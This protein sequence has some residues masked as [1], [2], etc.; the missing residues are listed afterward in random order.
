[1]YGMLQTEN[2]S[3]QHSNTITNNIIDSPEIHGVRTPSPI[4]IEVARIVTRK[5]VTLAFVLFSSFP[6]IQL[7]LFICFDGVS[8]L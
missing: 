4:T 8:N 5:S 2:A 7:A 6:L 3:I 1:M